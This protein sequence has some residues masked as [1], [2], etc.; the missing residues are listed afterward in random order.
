MERV[1]EIEIG[2]HQRVIAAEESVVSSL[3]NGTGRQALIH[4]QL[5]DSL[6]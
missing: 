2:A 5:G 4:K 6:D 1:Q 3:C